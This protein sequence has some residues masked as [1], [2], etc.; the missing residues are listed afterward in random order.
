[1]GCD[2]GEDKGDDDGEDDD[3]GCEGEEVNDM[4]GMSS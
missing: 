2:A 4:E 3:E 1:M